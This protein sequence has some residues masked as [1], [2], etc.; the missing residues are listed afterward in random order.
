MA[1]NHL[2]HSERR[3]WRYGKTTI[4]F[5]LRHSGDIKKG[6]RTT[7]ALS[8]RSFSIY[9]FLLGI[10]TARIAALPSTKH[11]ENCIKFYIKKKA[12]WRLCFHIY[13]FPI[14]NDFFM[15]EVDKF[16]ISLKKHV[17]K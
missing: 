11:V 12:R 17:L 2:E 3:V 5:Y 13:D 15:I 7:L 14:L 6:E 1:R 8:P 9:R 4:H 16:P 10:L